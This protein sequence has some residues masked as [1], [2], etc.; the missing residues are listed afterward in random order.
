[1]NTHVYRLS[2]K[3][4]S[5]FISERDDSRHQ[6][7]F[8]FSRC[9]VPVEIGYGMIKVSLSS[10]SLL[11]FDLFSTRLLA[12]YDRRRTSNETNAEEVQ[13]STAHRPIEPFTRYKCILL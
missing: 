9:I 10:L 12:N 7:S 2:K 8:L 5:A 11:S 1:M 13:R 6:T 3:Y 4:L